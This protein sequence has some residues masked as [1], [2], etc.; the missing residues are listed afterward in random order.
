M[1][2]LVNA[3]SMTLESEFANVVVSL[4][5]LEGLARALDPN[6]DVIKRLG[7]FLARELTGVVRS[8]IRED[9]GVRS[10]EDLAPAAAIARVVGGVFG[11]APHFATGFWGAED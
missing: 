2:S 6:I 7:P 1:I 5:T 3:Y 11:N 4:S 9:L 8:A 10:I